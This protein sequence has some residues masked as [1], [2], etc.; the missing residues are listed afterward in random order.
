MQTSVPESKKIVYAHNT[1][2]QT[3]ESSIVSQYVRKSYTKIKKDEELKQK[4]AL[5]KEQELNNTKSDELMKPHEKKRR[6]K[7]S[8]ASIMAKDKNISTLFKGIKIE[9]SSEKNESKSINANSKDDENYT[10]EGQLEVKKSPKKVKKS[11]KSK[12]NSASLKEKSLW[13]KAKK[14]PLKIALQRVGAKIG[15]NIYIRIFKK[16][17]ELEVWIKPKKSERYKLLKIYT[18]CKY[19]GGL[20]PK[21]RQGD[22]KSPEGFYSVYYS[23]LNPN[24]NFH[25]SFNLGFPNQYDKFHGYSGSYLMVH[26]KCA[27]IGCYAMGDKNIED[28]YKLV[29]QALLNGQLSVNVHIFPF[30]MNKT[31]LAHYRKSKWYSFWKSLKKGY[32]IFNSSHKVPNVDVINGKYEISVNR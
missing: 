6:V 8:I 31:T 10:I 4:A 1:T 22:K 32:D 17:S 15:D 14:E 28:I 11:Q 5:K 13:L 2:M 26:G 24:S 30:R 18:I 20:G 23:A 12:K 29:E 27:S 7:I 9:G 16:S 21:Q 25:L 19:S 3:S